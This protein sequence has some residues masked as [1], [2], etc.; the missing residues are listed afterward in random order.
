MSHSSS[1]SK[2]NCS[3]IDDHGRCIVGVDLSKDALDVF[4]HSKSYHLTNDECGFRQLLH[5]IKPAGDK[6]I[7]AY[8]S[9]GSLSRPF[10]RK[11]IAA[12]LHWI[13]L[14]P[15]M[16]RNFARGI[17]QYAKTD[18]IDAEMIARYVS[19]V[20]P[21]V[22]HAYNNKHLDMQDIYGAIELLKRSVASIKAACKASH[23]LPSVLQNLSDAIESLTQRIK[24]LQKELL[25]M[26]MQDS[27]LKK[28]YELYLQEPGI[29][30]EIALCLVCYL[31]ELGL[32]P[33]KRI[34]ALV[35]VAPYNWQS[36]NSNAT[37]HIYG[38]RR[39]VRDML[40]MAGIAIR[41]CK[42]G[43]QVK[44]FYLR[45]KAAGKSNKELAINCAHK[46]LRILNAKTRALLESLSS[47]LPL[48]IP[49]PS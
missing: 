38:G 9:T 14:Q 43:G 1:N 20:R 5:L 27:V 3:Y 21:Q 22:S 36:G 26:I 41:R 11:L 16:V 4:F 25:H 32:Q 23:V 19:V 10:T 15:Y 29:G 7:L 17:G 33:G 42:Q 34:S 39:Q 18:K 46:I 44:E 35:G 31:P 48:S 12:G 13:C 6:V 8:E 28:R 45:Q 30:M 2:S 37:R 47:P 49:R 40:Y 24:S